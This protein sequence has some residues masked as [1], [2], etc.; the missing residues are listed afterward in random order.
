VQHHGRVGGGRH[1]RL[2]VDGLGSIRHCQPL[3]DSVPHP[4][5]WI[6]PVESGIAVDK[7]VEDMFRSLAGNLSVG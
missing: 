6:R 7:R 1:L 4:G 3:S 2:A 5:L